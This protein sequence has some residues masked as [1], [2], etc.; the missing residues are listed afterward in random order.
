VDNKAS[1]NLKNMKEKA[2]Y[3]EN[4]KRVLEIYG[5]KCANYSQ[6]HSKSKPH[7][8]HIVFKSDMG[9]FTDFPINEKGNLIALCWKCEKKVHETAK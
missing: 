7:V 1:V 2:K 4:R 6:C 8:H 9:T 5:K 3:L